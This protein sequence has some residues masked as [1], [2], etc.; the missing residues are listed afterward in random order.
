MGRPTVRTQGEARAYTLDFTLRHQQSGKVFVAEMK[1]WPTFE[2]Y[3]Y[4]RLTETA[5]LQRIK[6]PAFIKFLA[7]SSNPSDYSV[8]VGNR[9]VQID[10]TV[11]I[12]GAAT[13]S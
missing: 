11:L 8:F 3:R 10:G 12:W 9:H 5:Q 7:L 6:E 4:L 1:C 2:N 13:A